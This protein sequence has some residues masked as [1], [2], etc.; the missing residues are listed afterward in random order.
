MKGEI[1]RMKELIK[2]KVTS[3]TELNGGEITQTV[4]DIFFILDK[5]IKR[6]KYNIYIYI[7]KE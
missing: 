6:V 1:E 5:C 4:D 2:G 7:Y 3:T